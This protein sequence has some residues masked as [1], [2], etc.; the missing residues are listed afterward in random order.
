MESST[1]SIMTLGVL[2][3]FRSSINIFRGTTSWRATLFI[4]ISFK[5]QFKKKS[6]IFNPSNQRPS[7]TTTENTT[8]K[9]T[10]VSL[11]QI[12]KLFSSSET[13]FSVGYI[14]PYVSIPTDLYRHI[15]KVC[16][17]SKTRRPATNGIFSTLYTF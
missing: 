10:A 16:K 15:V 12:W 5:C 6:T 4:S 17:W 9:R 1:S 3:N 14:Y 7:L 2:S 8:G 13:R 11:C